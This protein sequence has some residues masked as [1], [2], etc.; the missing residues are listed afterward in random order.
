M[1][2]AGGVDHQHLR[3]DL[4]GADGLLEQRFFPEGEQ[5]RQVGP[6]AARPTGGPASW[7]VWPSSSASRPVG[8]G[9]CWSA[10]GRRRSTAAAAMAATSRLGSGPPSARPCGSPSAG[11]TGQGPRPPPTGTLSWRAP[12]RAASGPPTRSSPS[13]RPTAEVAPGQAGQG[14]WQMP[15]RR[16]RWP[17][18]RSGAGRRP[19]RSPL[20]R[21]GPAPAGRA[22]QG[23]RLSDPG[24]QGDGGIGDLEAD[25]GRSGQ[26]CGGRRQPGV[27][28][29]WWTPKMKGSA[30]EMGVRCHAP[31]GS[32]RR[33]TRL[34][35]S[36]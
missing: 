19:A 4:Q 32:S 9:S 16:T 30:L 8:R 2:T 24:S 11:S 14:R 22:E 29:A 34:R 27:D 25:P 31:D 36:S 5:G 13:G 26:A 15:V 35:S 18:R 7:P 10:L 6:A 17:G 21:P 1:V 28:P 20:P 3:N 23:G 12:C 33:S